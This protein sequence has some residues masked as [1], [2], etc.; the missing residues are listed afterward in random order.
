MMRGSRSSIRREF[1]GVFVVIE[2]CTVIES[3]AISPIYRIG[4]RN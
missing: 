1:D 3:V 4:L 2:W